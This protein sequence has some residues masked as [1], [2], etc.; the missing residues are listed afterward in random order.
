MR[1]LRPSAFYLRGK[2]IEIL[3]LFCNILHY[4]LRWEI[5]K[6]I[7]ERQY[8]SKAH[9]AEISYQCAMHEESVFSPTDAVAHF[10]LFERFHIKKKTLCSDENLGFQ[11]IKCEEI[12]VTQTDYYDH[13]MT[14]HVHFAPDMT[15]KDSGFVNQRNKDD[16]VTS[17]SR[18]NKNTCQWS[19]TNDFISRYTSQETW[20]RHSLIR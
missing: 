5:R 9:A 17:T 20:H 3:F 2:N 15:V 14:T 1:F 10:T 16:R 12:S 8:D 11:S 4:E 18:G 13:L 19:E 6:S 7:S